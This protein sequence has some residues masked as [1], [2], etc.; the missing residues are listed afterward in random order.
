MSNCSMATVHYIVRANIPS[1]WDIMQCDVISYINQPLEASKLHYPNKIP[2]QCFQ[3]Y[4]TERKALYL[5]LLK[6]RMDILYALYKKAQKT[7]CK[8]DSTTKFEPMK[9]VY[10]FDVI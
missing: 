8:R 10:G 3:Y 5:K 2:Y 4:E 6:K 7:V 1:P 9:I